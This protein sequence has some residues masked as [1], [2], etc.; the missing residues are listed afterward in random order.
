MEGE[1]AFP[2]DLS[3]TLENSYCFELVSEMLQKTET[4]KMPCNLEDESSK[5]V[6]DSVI[7]KVSERD[8]V[9]SVLSGKDRGE[10]CYDYYNLI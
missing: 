6:W 4:H 2:K 7:N 1:A 8:Q 5:I 10:L 9:C 3:S